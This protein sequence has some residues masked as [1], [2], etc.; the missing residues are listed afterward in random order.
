MINVY[1][2]IVIYTHAGSTLL[3]KMQKHWLHAQKQWDCA[4]IWTLGRDNE[5]DVFSCLLPIGC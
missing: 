2:Y 1:I 5:Y 4:G 3:G